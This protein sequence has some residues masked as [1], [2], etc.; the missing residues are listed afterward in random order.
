MNLYLIGYRGT[1]KTTTASAVAKRLGWPCADTDRELEMRAGK[2]IANVFRD[3]GEP[4]FRDLES[5]VVAEL[6]LRAGWV[7]SLGGGA[8]LR[9]ENRLILAAS[10]RCVWLTATPATIAARLAADPATGGQ[11][12]NLTAHGGL[13]EIEQVLAERTPLYRELAAWTLATDGL[14][15]DDV[16]AEIAKLWKAAP[17]GLQ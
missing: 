6:S 10:G 14:S 15:P 11:R 12:P 4:A 16:A 13:A 1:G 3:D 9:K 17:P 8:I 7:V 5:Q 2:S